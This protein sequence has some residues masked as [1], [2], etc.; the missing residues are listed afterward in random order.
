MA[1]LIKSFEITN[2]L[3]DV[4]L[5]TTSAYNSPHIQDS[6]NSRRSSYFTSR[7]Y[8]EFGPADFL[9]AMYQ[10]ISPFLAYD[11]RLYD[12]IRLKAADALLRSPSRII[13]RGV[14]GGSEKVAVQTQED[15]TDEILGQDAW[16]TDLDGL[17]LGVDILGEAVAEGGSAQ[18]LSDTL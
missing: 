17:D 10:T 18:Q 11:K 9:H 5:C 1:Q 15:E 8:L 2:T 16:N 14:D 6:Y 7:E 13:P 3:A 12:M 4:I